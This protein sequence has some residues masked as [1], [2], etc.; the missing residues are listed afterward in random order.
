MKET[1]AFG[2][3][4]CQETLMQAHWHAADSCSKSCL[5]ASKRGGG[6][7]EGDDTVLGKLE[8]GFALVAGL[9][10]I[11]HFS[12]FSNGPTNLESPLHLWHSF[13][14]PAS[15]C[16]TKYRQTEPCWRR[17]GFCSCQE[18]AYLAYLLQL[19]TPWDASRGTWKCF[20]DIH[21]SWSY[22]R[23]AILHHI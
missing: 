17:C 8:T 5:C 9:D 14:W 23:S 18:M 15:K 13:H 4:P 22:L 6:I 3:F 12:L 19:S 11:Y 1:V 20:Y 7:W 10:F 2:C 16:S 21:P